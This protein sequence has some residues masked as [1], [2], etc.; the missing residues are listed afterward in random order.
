M[1]YRQLQSFGEK[2]SFDVAKIESI[3]LQEWTRATKQTERCCYCTNT[4]L[5]FSKFIEVQKFQNKLQ[6]NN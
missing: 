6:E 4:V 1:F 5:L 2:E 3:F